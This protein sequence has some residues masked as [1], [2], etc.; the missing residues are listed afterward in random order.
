MSLTEIKV[1]KDLELK[2]DEDTI[3]RNQTPSPTYTNMLPRVP[4]KKI[5]VKLKSS[6][7]IEPQMKSAGKNDSSSLKVQRTTSP[8]N[9]K[10][11]SFAVN[12]LPANIFLSKTDEKVSK[13]ATLDVP[14]C[15][16]G[17]VELKKERR[18]PPVTK[19]TKV[20]KAKNVWINHWQL[21]ERYC[22]IADDVLYIFFSFQEV[23][24]EI[25]MELTNLYIG[26][27]FGNNEERGNTV[28]F[29]SR[30]VHLIL[31]FASEKLQEEFYKTSFNAQNKNASQENVPRYV[32]SPII[33]KPYAK[34][35][36]KPNYINVVTKPQPNLN[37]PQYDS[38]QNSVNID[39]GEEEYVDM[40]TPGQLQ[41]TYS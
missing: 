5:K 8:E 9:Q 34:K 13:S 1:D 18:L 17:Y 32:A 7:S 30:E 25:S 22:G 12:S 2:I 3:D 40:L 36:P 39:S 15:E 29:Q 26:K 20:N 6:F 37:H 27:G 21:G 41:N 10:E 24:A 33:P 35:G 14:S 38:Q 19:F 28:L 16:P 11:K 23:H 31:V 4:T